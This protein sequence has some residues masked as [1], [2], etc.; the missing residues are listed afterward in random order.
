[1]S[2]SMS[3]SEINALNAQLNNAF[4]SAANDTASAI[5][6]RIASFEL[7]SSKSVLWTANDSL[8]AQIARLA[9]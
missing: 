1:M 6:A 4:G 5:D 2:K 8:D 3:K 7:N 9:R